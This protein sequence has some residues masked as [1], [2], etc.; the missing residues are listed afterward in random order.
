MSSLGVSLLILIVVAIASLAGYNYW[1]NRKSRGDDRGDRD[2]SDRSQGSSAQRQEPSFSG[3]DADRGEVPSA[4]PAGPAD[5][6]SQTASPAAVTDWRQSAAPVDGPSLASAEAAEQPASKSDWRSG[7]DA[8]DDSAGSG[9]G[10]NLDWRQAA[11]FDPTADELEEAAQ[12]PS[13][14]ELSDRLVG[15]IEKTLAEV[16]SASGVPRKVSPEVEPPAA[17]S[18]KILP[19]DDVL[20]PDPSA[21][22][23]APA[24]VPEPV[25]DAP[26]ELEEATGTETAAQAAPQTPLSGDPE[27]EQVT[28]ASGTGESDQRQWSGMDLDRSASR[29]VTSVTLDLGRP[30]RGS[31]LTELTKGLTRAGSKPIRV[32]AANAGD[33]VA[34]ELKA[35]P[36]D[37]STE[38]SLLRF[39]LLQVNRQGPVDGV[40]YSE[41]V[42]AVSE[43]SDKLDV[44]ADVPDMNVVLIRSRVLDAEVASLDAQVAVN[45]EAEEP[46][47]PARFAEVAAELKLRPAEDDRFANVNEQG[48]LINTVEL[49][50]EANRIVMI[51]DVPTIPR[52]QQPI[53]Q[54]VECAWKFA[55]AFEGKMIDDSGRLID[56]PLFERIE[57]QLD[58]HYQALLAAG[59]PAGSDLARQVYNTD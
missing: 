39:E 43:I 13:D 10:Q 56:N 22:S 23:V 3:P 52:E 42:N 8:A 40:E 47:D 30:V 45:V 20:P 14:S 24:E 35:Q 28:S 59:V 36:I 21:D 1:V 5:V 34:G 49:D 12:A 37:P 4:P 44:L 15:E 9:G 18:G 26:G 57:S 41:F 31:Q 16:E 7:G 38:Y 32:S 50:R 53:R 58:I 46:I 29:F 51:L 54:M 27:P 6:R 11:Q 55:Q 33:V 2:W 17:Q 25:D 48:W 19:A